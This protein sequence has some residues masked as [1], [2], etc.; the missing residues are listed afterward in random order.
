MKKIILLLLAICSASQSFAQEITGTQLLDKAIQFH[1]PNDN[2][3]NK[4]Q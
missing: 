3:K 4:I 1:D 2:W